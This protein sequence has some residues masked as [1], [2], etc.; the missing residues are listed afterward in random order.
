ME[1]NMTNG[2]ATVFN[3]IRDLLRDMALLGVLIT[4]VTL[5]V[6]IGEWKGSIDATC[7]NQEITNKRVDNDIVSIKMDQI[8][9]T[10]NV[11]AH[12]KQLIR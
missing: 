11:I 12:T 10:N 3:F 6:R 8:R 1:M 9:L 4:M 2:K 7:K 5:S